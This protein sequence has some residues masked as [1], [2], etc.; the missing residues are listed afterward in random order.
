[1]VEER[2]MVEL[3]NYFKLPVNIIFVQD[4]PTIDA[5]NHP[6]EHANRSIVL[7][8]VDELTSFAA[9]RDSLIS[10]KDRMTFCT[11]YN[12]LGIEVHKL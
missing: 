11:R 9:S 1:M 4:S 5:N 3:V 10:N 6:I 8:W 2:I 12:K 7:G